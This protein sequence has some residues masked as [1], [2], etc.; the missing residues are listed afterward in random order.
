[1]VQYFLL[2]ANPSMKYSLNDCLNQNICKCQT[3]VNI[4]KICKYLGRY[5]PIEMCH[6][7]KWN[8]HIKYITNKLRRLMYAFKNLTDILELKT[9]RVLYQALI[10]SIISY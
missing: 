6:N 2:K 3:F 10:E 1:M 8:A 7:L 4:V 9:I 5:L